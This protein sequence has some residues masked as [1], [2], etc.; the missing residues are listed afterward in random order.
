LFRPLSILK[1]LGPAGVVFALAGTLPGIAGVLVIANLRALGEHFQSQG[2]FGALQLLLLFTLLGGTMVAPTR[3]FS[4]L[5]GWAFGV[6]LGLCTAMS[7]IVLAALVNYLWASA[8]C[9][10]RVI[11][12]LD[13]HPKTRTIYR[14]L[15]RSS[16]TRTFLVVL[17]V[18]IP[19]AAPFALTNVTLAA[20]RVYLPTVTIATLLGLLPQTIIL[21]SVAAHLGRLDD[22]QQLSPL[23]IAAGFA[24]TIIA[25]CILGLLARS[26]LRR[27]THP[28]LE[29]PPL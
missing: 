17:L 28:P 2:S 1:Q 14:T 29:T 9:G 8:I 5:C 22:R 15:L 19:P 26:A 24:V 23:Y 12:L 11:H 7:G 27:A 18:R 21:V 6:R 20:T 3:V 10:Q 25:F 16:F 13:N 4:V